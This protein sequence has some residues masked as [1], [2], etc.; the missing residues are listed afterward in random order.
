MYIGVGEGFCE[1]GLLGGLGAL[2]AASGMLGRHRAVLFGQ[3]GLAG[4]PKL[5]KK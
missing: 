5:Q 4:R 1:F 3:E 2:G